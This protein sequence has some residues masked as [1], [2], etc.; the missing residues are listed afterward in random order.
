MPPESVVWA[1]ITTTENVLRDLIED[2]LR[3]NLRDNWLTASGLSE[4]RVAKLAEA[5]AEERKRRA[6]GEV[7][8]RLI[9]YTNIW[10]LQKILEKHWSLFADVFGDLKTMRIYLERLTSF[11][12]PEMH[13][14]DLLP[15]EEHLVLGITGEIRNKVTI[16]R[17]QR[18]DE[19]E[20]FPRIEHA[21][22]SFGT[23]AGS[24]GDRRARTAETGL[25]LRPGDTVIFDLKAWDPE[26]KPWT[27]S[28]IGPGSGEDVFEIRG[29]RITWPVNDSHIR[30]RAEVVIYLHGGRDY[31]RRGGQVGEGYDDAVSFIYRVLPTK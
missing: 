6:G 31:H 10:D 23:V 28:V 26:G 11:R 7:N 17:S 3:E 20:Y 5:L 24:E 2:V 30:E 12:N 15:F 16:Y 29:D 18:N 27:W 4:D 1:D 22:D 13:G 14:R 8:Q 21:V 25:I 9:Y 19:P